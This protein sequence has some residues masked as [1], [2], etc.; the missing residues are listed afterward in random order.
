M[1]ENSAKE[2][3]E[4]QR[5]R[6]ALCY[7]LSCD[8]SISQKDNW[9]H[10]FFVSERWIRLEKL[11]IIMM[12]IKWIVSVS[13]IRHL[14]YHHYCHQRRLSHSSMSINIC[15]MMSFDNKLIRWWRLMGKRLYFTKHFVVE[16][17]HQ[18]HRLIILANKKMKQLHLFLIHFQLKV[19]QL[20]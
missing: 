11:I 7:L 13:A 4:Q 12:M 9:L 8:A 15:M 5:A 18:Q 2:G 3:G 10:R 16:I 17:Q 19:K 20:M 1:P 6:N 14:I